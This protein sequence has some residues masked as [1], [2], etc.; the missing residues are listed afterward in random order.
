MDIKLGLI[1]KVLRM[2]QSDSLLSVSCILGGV[3]CLLTCS[4]H[5]VSMGIVA[6][7]VNYQQV[8]NV[9]SHVVDHDHCEAHLQLSV[10]FD[11]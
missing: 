5:C 7:W 4:S 11:A 10:D 2:Q 8:N 6:H 1:T 9:L 3:M